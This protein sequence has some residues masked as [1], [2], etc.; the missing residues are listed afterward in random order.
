MTAH[1]A[2]AYHFHRLLLFVASV[3]QLLAYHD[4]AG[5]LSADHFLCCPS[6]ILLNKNGLKCK[7]STLRTFM[8][9]LRC[10]N[11]VYQS[12]SSD[13]GRMFYDLLLTYTT[14]DVFWWI[15]FGDSDSK[16]VCV[17][18]CVCVCV[19]AYVRAC[20]RACV[21]TCVRA[22][23]RACARAFVCS[24]IFRVVSDFFSHTWK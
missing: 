14:H 21:R 22:C 13:C 15:Y 1:L 8:N 11:G 12:L 6:N 3:E 20:V 10:G 5:C 18:V 16:V 2:L 17:C 7:T 19:R 23:V 24:G 4:V 9:T